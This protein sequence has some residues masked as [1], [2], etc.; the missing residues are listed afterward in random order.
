MRFIDWEVIRC[1]VVIARLIENQRANFIIAGPAGL[2]EP[3]VH[4][5]AYAAFE[6][7]VGGEEFCEAV[8][9]LFGAVSLWVALQQFKQPSHHSPIILLQSSLERRAPIRIQ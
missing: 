1:R 4:V 2:E 7:L 8:V 5:L 3:G 9:Y 6:V